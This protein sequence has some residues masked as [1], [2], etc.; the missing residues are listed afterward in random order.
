MCE[1]LRLEFQCISLHSIIRSRFVSLNSSSYRNSISWKTKND[2]S[3]IYIYDVFTHQIPIVHIFL[4]RFWFEVCVFFL[5]VC[6]KNRL[7]AIQSMIIII[8][9]LSSGSQRFSIGIF[10][11]SLS[12]ICCFCCTLECCSESCRMLDPHCVRNNLKKSTTTNIHTIIPKFIIIQYLSIHIFMTGQSS[13]NALRFH[14]STL[15]IVRSTKK[16]TT[17]KCKLKRNF[18]YFSSSVVL[19]L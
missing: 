5:S 16:R 10:F 17:S 2:F 6:M 15:E 9:N 3:C 12:L 4:F 11:S 19:L 14:R 18:Y 13:Y 7:T 8:L 1:F